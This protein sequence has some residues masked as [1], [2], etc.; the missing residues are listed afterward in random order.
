MYLLFLNLVTDLK[1]KAIKLKE[2]D[3]SCSYHNG[4]CSHTCLDRL[5]GHQCTC[6]QDMILAQDELNCINP[7]ARL[8]G[9]CYNNNGGCSHHCIVDQKN[10]HYC[11]CPKGY[12]LLSNQQGCKFEWN[13]I[14]NSVK[15]SA[16]KD[17]CRY[18]NGDCSHICIQIA[19]QRHYCRCRKGFKLDIDGKSCLSE[20]ISTNQ[21]VERPYHGC[22]HR[23]GGCQH[24]CIDLSRSHICSC[25]HGYL[26]DVDQKSCKLNIEVL[27]LDQGKPSVILPSS[28]SDY[29]NEFIHGA[30]HYGSCSQSN[31]SCQHICVD[32]DSTNYYCR[33]LLGYQLMQNGYNCRKSNLN[34]ELSI[35]DGSCR[36][37]NGYCQHLCVD[38]SDEGHYCLC[39]KG[40]SLNQ[41]RRTCSQRNDY[42]SNLKRLLRGPCYNIGSSCSHFCHTVRNYHYCSCPL[43]Y[44]LMPDNTTCDV[45]EC[46]SSHH[47]NCSHICINTL[48]SYRCQCPYGF[49]LNPDGL[50]CQSIGQ[51]NAVVV[52]CKTDR[53]QI[54]IKR[55][56]IP[57]EVN[58]SK[59]RLI[60]PKCQ[61]RL[62]RSYIA[63]ST[64]LQQCG[65]KV[66]E[67]SDKIIY[68]NT[69]QQWNDRKGII[70]RGQGFQIQLQCSYNKRAR[71][72]NI[73]IEPGLTI[74]TIQIGQG[75]G[76]LTFKMD[77]FNTTDYQNPINSSAPIVVELQQ[78]LYF[79][80]KIIPPQKNLILF[81]EQCFATPEPTLNQ[82]IRYNII[83]NGCDIDTTIQ[84][85]ESPSPSTA[86]FSLYPFQFIGNYRFVFFHCQILLCHRF[87]SQSRCS[88]G[89]VMDRSSISNRTK[90]D[91][92]SDVSK[93][94]HVLQG[95]FILINP[96]QSKSLQAREIKNQH[97]N[98]KTNHDRPHKSGIQQSNKKPFP[99]TG[100]DDDCYRYWIV[101]TTSVCFAFSCIIFCVVL[102]VT[103]GCS[104]RYFI[105]SY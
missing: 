23:N 51:E 7:S 4:G 36:Q 101:A 85:Y 38:I 86:R 31:H 19:N 41:D 25:R 89:C 8:P 76:N 49:Q 96:R 103:K 88:R 84:H 40:Y 62:N 48:G 71:L 9:N 1:S 37:S 92:N 10:Y 26:L 91:F 99:V 53:I 43:G 100:I 12:K 105:P 61:P 83:Q 46:S 45:N 54:F 5:D 79:E 102:L 20:S 70:A 104:S 77:I 52:L 27:P 64:S 32:I 57:N 81:V 94:F 78:V 34:N 24:F 22:Q 58:P 75:R 65:H 2:M 13:A 14:S 82:S 29:P 59:L 16:K 97:T 33:C 63:F 95:P 18:R 35:L 80:I 6:P 21:A 47:H 30:K 3:S 68:H 50:T 44:D 66:T 93:S 11:T 56:F 42:N 67:S 39:R 73:A 55:Q 15:N 98:N 87:S 17:D 74:K 90:R 60:D 69:I 72:A 28:S